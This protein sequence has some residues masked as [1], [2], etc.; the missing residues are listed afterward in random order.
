[1]RGG[2]FMWRRMRDDW[3]LLLLLLPVLA[4]AV[5]SVCCPPCINGGEEARETRARTDARVIADVVRSFFTRHERWPALSELTEPDGR[6]R[7]ELDELPPDPWGNAYVM[8]FGEPRAGLRW[9]T[10]EVLS[11]G[12]DGRLA[13]S[14]DISSRSPPRR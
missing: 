5:L 4:A 6:G 11:A 7:R 13:T 9:Q 8:R 14:D 10:F 3:P 12:P 1:M 2:G